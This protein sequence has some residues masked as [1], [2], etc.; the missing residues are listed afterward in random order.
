MVI[1]LTTGCACLW[2]IVVASRQIALLLA[3]TIY[4]P[5]QLV[6]LHVEELTDSRTLILVNVLPTEGYISN[7]GMNI[8]EYRCD[9]QHIQN[10]DIITFRYSTR[11]IT[12]TKVPQEIV[13]FK[14]DYCTI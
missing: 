9:K 14:A 10:S 1:K 11:E 2:Y 4:V 8:A 5:M 6:H 12:S 3:T 13:I 7:R